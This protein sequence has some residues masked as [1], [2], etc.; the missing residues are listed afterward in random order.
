MRPPR[1]RALGPPRDRPGPS[2]AFSS[3]WPEWEVTW[4]E[5][6]KDLSLA[7]VATE[8]ARPENSRSLCVVNLKRQAREVL[9]NLIASG[10]K[11]A[12]HLSTSMCPAH[13]QEILA[14]VRGLLQDP[15][16]PPVRLVSTQCVEAGV[17]LDFPVVWRAWGPLT[18]IAQAAG[19]CNRNGNLATGQVRVFNLQQEYTE[20]GRPK[21]NYPDD[22]YEQ[23]AEA[24][25]VILAR[26]GAANMDIEDPEIFRAFYRQVYAAQGA[27]DPAN[28]TQLEDAIRRRHFEE[29]ARFYRLIDKDA[30]NILVPYDP[31]AFQ[32]LAQQARDKGLSRAWVARAR[33]HTV[34]WFRPTD[35]SQLMGALEPI[36]LLGMGH[37]RP[38]KMSSDWFICPAEVE[39]YD[40][41]TGLIPPEGMAFWGV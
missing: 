26:I 5:P 14:Q 1:R 39:M 20:A 23:A 12:F 28:E 7:Q 21:K 24:A 36:P 31:S 32:E 2:L 35:E 11:G 38:G 29:V 4:P 27:A 22:A 13:R 16:H 19:R 33:P 9:Q 30:I 40:P 37:K 25:K 6:E 8:L 17:D 34:G 15:A 3:G 41:V 18:S 10:S